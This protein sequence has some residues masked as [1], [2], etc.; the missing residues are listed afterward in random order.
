MAER[1]VLRFAVYFFKECSIK[2]EVLHFSY[3]STA[4]SGQMSLYF[5]SLTGNIQSLHC[6]SSS[7]KSHARQTYSLVNALTTVCCRYQLF[8]V[9]AP[10]FRQ[11]RSVQRNRQ[12]S[13]RTKHTAIGSTPQ[14]WKQGRSAG[15]EPQAPPLRIGFGEAGE[16]DGAVVGAGAGKAAGGTF[17]EGIGDIAHRLIPQKRKL[18]GEPFV[19]EREHSV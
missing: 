3:P 14:R 18:L 17:H 15:C 4:S 11:G 6:P 2:A 1:G 12:R 10:P 16:E 8:A 7:A 19:P 9:T 5:V 13:G